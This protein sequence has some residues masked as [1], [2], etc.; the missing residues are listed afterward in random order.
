M[1]K[2]KIEEGISLRLRQLIILAI[3]LMYLLFVMIFAANIPIGD[4]YWLLD[5]LNQYF[6]AADGRAKIELLLAF[7][8]EHRLIFTKLLALISISVVG[9][10]DFRLLIF[11]GNL[12]FI[13]GVFQLMKLLNFRIFSISALLTVLILINPQ[14]HKLMF[15]PMAAIQAYFGFL[16][17]VLY[18]VRLVR[19]EDYLSSGIFYFL[20]ML[21][22]ASGVFLIFIGII[23]SLYR[24][25]F[26]AAAIQALVFFMAAKIYFYGLGAPGGR[27]IDFFLAE[28]LI[29]IKFFISLL[30]VV[31]QVPDLVFGAGLLLLIYFFR[32]FISFKW[33]K[34]SA[35]PRSEQATYF[36]L[37]YVF[38]QVFLIAFGRAELY[39]DDLSH[40]ALDGRY[41]LYGLIFALIM[42]TF[43][44]SA[45]VAD[46][47]GRL[48]A[49][50]ILLGFL[51]FLNGFLF[52]GGYF[53]VRHKMEKRIG[54][55]KE[56]AASANAAK[57]EVFAHDRVSA[58][59]IL[60]TA[61]QN[62]LF[63][64]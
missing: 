23:F 22:S 31:I 7:H 29:P 17:S 49:K 63:V 11:L 18:I 13:A 55:I 54:G 12:A 62:K 58:T 33:N 26:T 60:N 16:F 4:D 3:P 6:S 56:F 51:I 61:I 14:A 52:I 36:L 1:L 44:Y 57:L 39:G 34:T 30:G 47:Q 19:D 41:R 53:V 21:C 50:K 10:L 15:Y 46:N 35:L 43:F 48:I 24:R 42:A 45:S 40:A 2:N 25:K 64:P 28:P 9:N 32:N 27:K 20:A 38:I 8:N 5:F 37:I 59:T